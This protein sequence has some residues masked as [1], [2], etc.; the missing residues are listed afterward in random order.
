[1][2]WS[3]LIER[4]LGK[5]MFDALL[6]ENEVEFLKVQSILKQFP[7]ISKNNSINYIFL[8]QLDEDCRLFI[9]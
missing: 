9:A 6:I 4:L 8:D 2:K 3:N 7:D 5:N 1:M